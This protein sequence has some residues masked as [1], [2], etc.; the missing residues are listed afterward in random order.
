MM[1]IESI[2]PGDRIKVV[3]VFGFPGHVGIVKRV[4][5]PC[6]DIYPIFIQMDNGTPLSINMSELVKIKDKPDME[7]NTQGFVIG[8]RV[9]VNGQK[10]DPSNALPELHGALGTIIALAPNH[11]YPIEV[12][13]DRPT[14]GSPQRHK[15]LL[16][17]YSEITRANESDLTSS[18]ILVDWYWQKD[19]AQS[20]NQN[21]VVGLSMDDEEFTVLLCNEDHGTNVVSIPVNDMYELYLALHKFYESI[22]ATWT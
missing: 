22:G 20:Q 4:Y 6:K 15:K 3:N 21:L 19:H 2:C 10:Y 13:L 1:A 9:R 11:S 18:D 5:N 7:E 12:E 16:L 14:D 8:D 17:T